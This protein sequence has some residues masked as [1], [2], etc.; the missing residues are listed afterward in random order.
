MSLKQIFHILL[1]QFSA[2]SLVQNL[3]F[4]TLFALLIWIVSV[5][6]KERAGKYKIN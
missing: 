4:Y 3:G 1:S 2:G 6:F 5:Q